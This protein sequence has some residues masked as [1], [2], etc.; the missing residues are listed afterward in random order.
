MAPNKIA[1]MLGRNSGKKIFVVLAYAFL[2]WFL[3]L[4]L[5]INSIFSYM[6]RKFAGYFHLKQPCILCSRIDHLLEPLTTTDSYKS[7]VCENHA[8]EISKLGYCSNHHK[9]SVLQQMCEECFDFKPTNNVPFDKSKCTEKTSRCSC[10]EK[11]S[12]KKHPPLHFPLREIQEEADG[13]ETEFIANDIS[14][15]SGSECDPQILSDVGSLYLREAAENDSN[16]DDH[17]VQDHAGMENIKHLRHE[18][19]ILP[20]VEADHLLLSADER[21][22]SL[23]DEKIMDGNH[24]ISCEIKQL[25]SDL[26]AEQKARNVLYGEL[27]A[28]RN[29]AAI[30]ANQTMAMITRLQEEKAAMQMEGL[31]YQRVME[32]QAEYDQEA[33]QLLNELVAKRERQQQELEKELDIYRERVSDYEAKEKTM[34]LIQKCNGNFSSSC[35]IDNDSDV[36]SINLNCHYNKVEDNNI[37]CSPDNGNKDS[38]LMDCSKE[39]GAI[40]DSLEELEEERMSIINKLKELEEK[41]HKG[42]NQDEELFEDKNIKLDPNSELCSKEVNLVYSCFSNS[43]TSEDYPKTMASVARKLLDL[44]ESDDDTEIEDTELSSK[45]GSD[46]ELEITRTENDSKRLAIEKEMDH[47]YG[48][49]QALEAD[50]EFLR[51]CIASVNKGN[52]GVNLLQEILQ[53]LREL[54]DAE[55]CL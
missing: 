51:H 49:L 17:E 52:E 55:I 23:L 13:E 30:A 29:A 21:N 3:I 5:L 6:I 12:S 15:Q 25:K 18:D 35:S 48:R 10:C 26:E 31:Q 45:V 8:T 43:I 7:L 20:I 36:L 32:E 38:T 27:E 46:K 28:E 22:S 24:D 2:E 14:N 11:I 4:L 34:M 54:R 19:R 42:A 53:H 44:V 9:F 33:L 50:S 40:E 41:L 39:W 37:S 1:S 16:E 47:V